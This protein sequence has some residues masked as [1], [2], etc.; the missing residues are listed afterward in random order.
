MQFD[1]LGRTELSVSRLGFGSAPVG[2]L[3]TSQGQIDKVVATLLEAGVNLFDTAA[4][5]PGSEEALGH[6][7][8]GRR[9]DVV[10]VTKAGHP[11]DDDAHGHP[12]FSPEL[13]AASVDRSLER[14]KTDHL[15]VVL[16]HTCTLEQ[17]EEGSA[18]GALLDARD[19]GKTRFVGF[20]GDNEAAAFAAADAG[21][22]VLEVSVNLADQHNLDAVLPAAREHHKGVIAKRPLAN[23]CWKDRDAQPGM[24]KSY[25]DA[26]SRR[27]AAMEA[28][29]LS[30][31]ALGHSGHVEVEWPDVALRFTLAHPGVSSAIIGSTSTVHTEMNL[32]AARKNPLR[33]EAVERI[34]AAWQAARAARR[35]AAAEDDE[36]DD[37]K[38]RT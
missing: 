28:E 35:G 12:A 29:G 6:A 34:R 10:I 22:D 2:F 8:A 26:Y 30:P 24:Y 19:A 4:C 5:Y 23:A 20:A 1:L 21:V 25:A 32:D 16:L 38:G 14:L 33:E 31:A 17:L 7:L 15:D 11:C 13:L 18:L 37:W 36:G 27:L 9:D 3:G